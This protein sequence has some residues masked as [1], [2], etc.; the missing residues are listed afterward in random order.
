M[1][2]QEFFKDIQEENKKKYEGYDA[3]LKSSPLVQ[4]LLKR[5]KENAEKHKQ[6]IQ[7]KYC[8]RGA[9][10]GVGDCS[11]SAMSEEQREAFLEA[12]KEKEAPQ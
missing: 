12:F 1:P 6:E 11:L 10:W 3:K 8:R 9:D 2:G 7:D 4:E 5:S